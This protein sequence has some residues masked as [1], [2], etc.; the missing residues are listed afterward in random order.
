MGGHAQRQ[1]VDA[2]GRG[3]RGGVLPYLREASDEASSQSKGCL[4]SMGGH[5]C[6]PRETGVF[7]LGRSARVTALN[8][9]DLD[10]I[11]WGRGGL[12]MLIGYWLEPTW[13]ESSKEQRPGPILEADC[14]SCSLAVLNV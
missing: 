5:R 8:E 13:S 7:F 14:K 2:L 4:R 3:G 9:E 1:G 6:L 11:D 10:A 12:R